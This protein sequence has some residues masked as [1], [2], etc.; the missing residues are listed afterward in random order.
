MEGS[1]TKIKKL[2]AK[3]YIDGANLFYTQKSLGWF[4]DFKKIKE[5]L[6]KKWD[7]TGIK[8]YTGVRESDERMG[9]F[10]RYLD[11]L[12]IEPITKP[13]K[14]IINSKNTIF[15][16]N[17]DVEMTMDILLERQ[18]YD[19]CILFSGD[20]DFHAL[21]EKLKNFG[22]KIIVFSS[23]KMISWELKLSVNQYIFLEDLKDIIK[24]TSARR[25]SSV[26][27]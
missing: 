20:S 6:I 27:L 10:L 7:I 22:K 11:N 8:Y 21:V 18:S 13:L 3:V 25:R 2:K 16:S 19:V 4:L 24:K 14:K 17:F 15:K 9:S 23:R 1:S 5:Y 12:E 26:K